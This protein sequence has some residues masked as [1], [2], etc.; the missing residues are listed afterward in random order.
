MTTPYPYQILGKEKSTYKFERGPPRGLW[1]L[2]WIL[3]T[4]LRLCD[5]ARNNNA[6]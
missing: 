1:E 2:L 3:A 4:D 5:G 6:L